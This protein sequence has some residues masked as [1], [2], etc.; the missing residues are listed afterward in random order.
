MGLEFRNDGNTD[1]VK[2]Y[3]KDGSDTVYGSNGDDRLFGGNGNDTLNGSYGDDT[4]EGGAGDDE[5]SGDGGSDVYYGG[6]GDD[7]FVFE[8]RN[9]ATIIAPIILDFDRADDLLVFFEGSNPVDYGDE[10]NLLRKGTTVTNAN[11][12]AGIAQFLYDTDS[13]QLS[14]DINGSTAGGVL[15]LCVLNGHPTLTASDFYLI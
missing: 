7:M 6:S 5:L 8:I 1:G 4:I 13:G 3:G 14:V 12:A 10:L 11:T 9:N 2:I 15:L